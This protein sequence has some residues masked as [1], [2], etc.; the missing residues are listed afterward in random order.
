LERVR[1]S[2]GTAF[3]LSVIPGAGHVYA[4]RMGEGVAWLV[5]TI[6]AYRKLGFFFGLL[7]HGACA[8]KAAQ[9]AQAANRREEA[10][11]ASRRESASQVAALLDGA[12]PRRAPAAAPPAAAEAAPADP[13]PRVM[14]AAFPT[15]PGRLVGALAEAMAANGLLV[16]G[17]DR[18]HLRVRGSV[19]HGGGRHTFVVAQ[20]EG[21]PTGSRVRLLMDRPPGSPEDPSVDDESLRAILE[22]TEMLLGGPPGSGPDAPAVSAVRGMGEA[23]TEDHF[24][25]QLREAWESYEQGWLPEQEWLQRKASLVRSVVLRPGTRRSDF[26]AACRPLVEAGVL[27]GR[28][29]DNLESAIP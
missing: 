17:V 5:G 6:L 18:E 1:K 3:L 13:P 4:G 20:V 2:A 24:L 27:D 26:L 16:L 21:T 8:V 14:R 12:V 15:E 23:L 22:R 10:D 7:V 19:D 25:E 11:L 28:D 9:V 29:L